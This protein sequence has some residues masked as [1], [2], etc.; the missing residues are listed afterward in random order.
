MLKAKKGSTKKKEDVVVP[1]K[2]VQGYK[3]IDIKKVVAPK[4]AVRFAVSDESVRDLT[5]S[6]RKVGLIQPLVVKQ[7]GKKFEVVAGHRRLMACILAK[8]KKV[9]CIV[10]EKDAD[11]EETVKLHEN[12]VRQDLSVVEEAI[13]IQYLIQ[14]RE[15]SQREVAEI[16]NVSEGY[17]SQ[18]VGMLSWHEKLIEAVDSGFISFTSARELA[19]I[20]DEDALLIHVQQAVE[21]GVTPKVANLWFTDW[22]KSKNYNLHGHT[23]KEF[24]FV[25]HDPNDTKFDCGMCGETH[26][27]KDLVYTR[28]CAGCFRAMMTAQEQ[29][30]I[31]GRS[32]N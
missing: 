30:R 21:H 4:V 3:L 27:Y 17:V 11:L 29:L 1:V 7:I 24:E 2:K 32:R 9:K 15:K 8:E 19:R 6:I 20:T 5:E 25:D 23:G 16:L 28:L 13:Y 22:L 10:M 12:I 18:R 31:E 26:V 14:F